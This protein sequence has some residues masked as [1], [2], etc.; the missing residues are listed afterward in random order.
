MGE[1]LDDLWPQICEGQI[2]KSFSFTFPLSGSIWKMEGDKQWEK[3]ST[4]AGP[5]GI[6]P[7]LSMN[8]NIKSYHW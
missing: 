5:L 4:F 8:K 1:F 6:P 2:I 7:Y 3:K